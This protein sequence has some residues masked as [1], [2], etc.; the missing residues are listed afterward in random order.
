MILVTGGA[1][2]IGSNFVLDWLA[3]SDE[4]VVN[5]DKL[6]YAGNLANLAALEGDARHVFVQGD[7]GDRALVRAICSRATGRAPS[8]TSPRRATSTGRSTARP[9]SCRPTSSAP[10]PCSR[11]R[12]RHWEGLKGAAR[13]AF[14]FLHVSTDEVYGSLGPAD[15]AFTR[16]D[17]VRAQQPVRRVEGGL[18]PPGARL[19]PHLRPA[20]ADHELLEQLRALPVSREA[21]SAHDRQRARRQAAAGLRRRRRTCATGSTST[22]TAPRCAPCSSAGASASA[23]TSAA[24][25]R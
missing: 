9:S 23:T 1:G 12:A 14:R 15:P 25:P 21:D 13:E 6:T 24:R 3:Q 18:R 11:R 5:L 19:P 20:D 17:A 8:C 7:I 10:S 16:D 2:F 4:G 22:T